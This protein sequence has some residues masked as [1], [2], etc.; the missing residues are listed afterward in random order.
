[1]RQAWIRPK[2]PLSFKTGL[3]VLNSLTRTKEEFWPT[4]GERNVYWYMCGPTVY[5]NAHMGHARTYICFDTIRRIL[6]DYFGYH[7]TL[8][9]NITDIDDKIILNSKNQDMDWES[10]ARKWE[11]DF[12]EDMENLNVRPPDI[13]TRVSE[14]VPEII[15]YISKVIDNGFAYESNGSV[16][17]DTTSFC[18]KHCY[19]KLEPSAVNNIELI[20]EGEGA[21]TQVDDPEKK[22]MGDFAL[23]KKSKPGEPSWESP[24]GPGRPGWHIECSVMA[25]HSLPEVIDIHS[26][27]VDLRF[28]HHDNEIAQSEAFYDKD[29]W[30]WVNYF[31][32]TGHLHIDGLKMSKSL[33]N[34]KTIKELQEKFNARQIR[35]AFLLQRWDCLMNYSE[36]SLEE[37]KQ[38]EKQFNEFFMNLQAVMRELKLETTQKLQ[39]QDKELFQ[40][41]DTTKDKVHEYMCDNFS[42]ERVI[43]ELAKLVNKTN[44]YLQCQPKFTVLES[45]RNY[46]TWLLRCIGLNYEQTETGSSDK[47][48]RVMD[49]LT[50][51]RDKVR[52]SAKTTKNT[53]VLQLCDE[54][55][56]SVLPEL[57]I[58]L[59]DRSNQG[60][61][62][63]RGDPLDI[64][65][66]IQSKKEQE[67]ESKRKKEQL[68]QLKREREQQQ[69]EKASVHPT[70]MF[71]H[72]TDTYSNWDEGGIPTHDAKGEPVSKSLRKKLQKEWD[73]QKKLYEKYNS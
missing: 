13:L 53:E 2:E 66:E 27:G 33:K 12:F 73:K 62:W 31:L 21:L 49:S 64:M 60:A 55:R 42:T 71:L 20:Q 72:M 46:T 10:F 7:V 34:F 35:M 25:S 68:A 24:W 43:E 63:K 38:K 9:M 70:Q 59:E 36:N 28:P 18:Q 45:I 26:G 8:C 6:S 47:F 29:N 65:R 16:Y 51:F 11:N 37:A 67:E 19:G 30:Q 15:E 54:M 3:K 39:E 14:F 23:W 69:R 57:G 4:S 52:N 48:D 1:M 56:D 44:K 5:S 17:F 40:A 50:E 41:L 22:R 61:V 58:K 32:H